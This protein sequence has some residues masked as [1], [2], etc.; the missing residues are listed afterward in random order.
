MNDKKSVPNQ[1]HRKENEKLRKIL[2]EFG[3]VV[4]D[5]CHIWEEG[6]QITA[7]KLIPEFANHRNPYMYFRWCWRDEMANEYWW[8]RVTASFDYFPDDKYLHPWGFF[9]VMDITKRNIHHLPLIEK[10]IISAL[11]TQSV[12]V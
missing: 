7:R 10:R 2:K 11:T 4:W 1:M 5:H 9:E 6:Y 8:S 12:L 3:F